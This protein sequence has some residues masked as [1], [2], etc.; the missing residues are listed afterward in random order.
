[1]SA[2]FTVHGVTRAAFC[3]LKV[4]LRLVPA[5]WYQ[6]VL[7]YAVDLMYDVLGCSQRGCGLSTGLWSIYYWVVYSDIASQRFAFKKK[8]WSSAYLPP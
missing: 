6:G 4:S 8:Q 2:I 3:V 1:M 5:V 7:G